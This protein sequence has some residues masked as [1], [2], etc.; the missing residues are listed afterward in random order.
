M[1][2]RNE[3]SKK[4][5]LQKNLSAANSIRGA[6]KTGKTVAGAAKGAAIGG[7]YG[8][9]AGA[10]WENRHLVMKIVIGIAFIFMLPILFLLMLPGLIFEGF[11]LDESL[12]NETTILNDDLAIIENVNE[13][14]FSINEILAESLS[15][16][17][18]EIEEDFLSSGANQKEIINLYS[19]SPLYNTNM[20]ISMFC[21]AN[22]MSYEKIKARNLEK[23]LEREKKHLYSYTK[24]TEESE[25]TYT[26]ESSGES[27]IISEI[28]NI[29][30]I[31]YNGE[32]YFAEKI[33]KLSNEQKLLSTDYAYN[34]SVFLGDKR[35]IISPIVTIF[36][37]IQPL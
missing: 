9:V 10:L 27:I 22:E 15:D 34:L 18:E 17:L 4:N 2:N 24:T 25:T 13:I 12:E 26:I 14:S 32:E 21:S 28:R 19:T 23:Q 6:L 11:S 37:I 29:Y 36:F 30:T 5:F 20:F 8:A 3:N 35:A 16:L 33:F 1:D 7:P 31:I